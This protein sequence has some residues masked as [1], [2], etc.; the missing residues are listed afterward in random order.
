MLFLNEMLIMW[1]KMARLLLLMSLRGALCLGD[2][3]AMAFIKHWKQKKAS[4]LKMKTK[5]WLLLPFKTF[6]EK[7]KRG[8]GGG[9][10]T[11]KRGVKK[12]KFYCSE[13]SFPQKKN[14]VTFI[15]FFFF[16]K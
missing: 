12:K 10:E 15:F 8:G 16:F 6:L 11:K 7:K 14:P 9:R 5:P 2:V 13:Y 3:T 1:S 4:P